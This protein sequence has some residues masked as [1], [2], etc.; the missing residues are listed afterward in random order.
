[1]KDTILSPTYGSRAGENVPQFLIFL[2]ASKSQDNV[3]DPAGALKTQGVVPFGVGVKDADPK[4][5]AA[6]SHN[7]SFAFNVKEF[8][9]LSA[10]HQRLNN[11]VSLPNE[12]LEEIL[13]QGKAKYVCSFSAC[14]VSDLNTTD[15]RRDIVFLLDGSDE[16]RN[17]LPAIREFIRRITD[18]LDIDGEMIR[19]AVVQYSDNAVPHFLF[20][21]HKTKKDVIYAVRSLRPKGGGSLNTGAALQYVRDHVFVPTSGNRH[22]M[23]VPQVLLVLTGRK[24]SD[25]VAGPAADLRRLGILTFAIGMKN[26]EEKELRKIAYSARFLFNLPSFGELLSIQSDILTFFQS[27][28]EKEPPT[29][30]VELD[31]AQRDIV[32][33]LDGSEDTRD[34]FPAM[35]QFVENV[36]EKLTVNPNSDQVSVVQYSSDP[37]VYFHLNTYS[38]KQDVL[39]A[40]RSLRLKGGRPQNLGM[41]LDYVRKNVFVT[42]SGSRRLDGVPQI[43]IVLTGGRSQDDI[44]HPASSLKQENILSFTIGTKK[45]DIIQLQT[46]AHMPSYTVSIS[47]FED[48]QNIQQT[49]VSF[50]NDIVFLIDASDQSRNFELMQNFIERVVKNLDFGSNKNQ[51]AVVQYSREAAADFFLNTHLK[52]DDIIHNVRTLTKKGGGPLNTGAALQYVV[53]NTFDEATGS[54]HLEGVPQILILLNGGRSRDDIRG[55]AAEL[56]RTGVIPISIGTVGSDTLELQTISHKPNYFFMINDSEDL[57][58]VEESVLSLVKRIRDAT[59]NFY[60]NSYSTKADALNSIK[61]LQHKSGHQ[62]S[63]VQFSSTPAVDFYLN[64][65]TSRESLSNAIRNLKPKGGRP[66]YTGTALKF[67]K[68]NVFTQNAGSRHLDGAYQILIV[69]VGGRSRESV[70]GPASALQTMGVMTFAIGL[71]DNAEIQGIASQTDNQPDLSKRDIVFLVDGSDNTRNGFQAIRDFLY[72]VAGKLNVESAKDRISVIQF[73]NVAVAN[74]YLNS[75]TKKEDVLNSIKGL[76]HK[77]GRPLNTGKALQF[78][79]NNIFTASSGSRYKE[80]VPQI[81]VLVSS[82]RSKDTIDE[83]LSALKDIGVQIFPVGTRLSDKRELQ[84][85][86]FDSSFTLAVSE[87]NDLPLIQDFEFSKCI[88]NNIIFSPVPVKTSKKDVVFL[89]DGTDGTR[90]GFPAMKDFVQRL[91]EKLNITANKDRVSVVQYSREPE[92]H[93]YLNTYERKQDIV[94]TVR[95]LRHKGGRPLNTGAALQYVRDNVFTPSSGS[96]RLDG[97]PQMLILLSGGRSFDNVYTPASSL[98]ELG[99]QIFAIGTRSA[100]ST[101][102]QRISKDP[103]SAVS[104]SEF[105]DLPNVQQQLLAAVEKDVVF[106][107]DGSDGT[108]NGFPSMKDFVQRVV[109][110]LNVIDDKDR[111]AVVQYSREPEVHFYLNT[112]ERKQDVLDTVKGLTHKGGRPLNTG[113]ALQYVRDNVFTPSSGSRRLDGVPQMLILLSGGRSFDNVYTPATSLRDLGVQIFTIGSRNADSTELQRISKDPSS[114]IAVS[115]FTDLPNVQQQLLVLAGFT[116]RPE[117]PTVLGMLLRMP[118]SIREPEVHFYLNTYERKQDIVDTVRGLR[119]KGGRPLNTGAALQYVRDN[120]FTPSSG[121]RRLDGVPQMLILLSGGRSFDNVYTPASS[122]KELGV[123]IFAIGT[124]SADISEFTDLPNVQQQL[125]A[126]VESVAVPSKPETPTVLGMSVCFISAASI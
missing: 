25:D 55:P 78:V 99:V 62:V 105:T 63:V 109:E 42:S 111:V 49:L 91:V 121:S 56:K 100:D 32:F 10:V 54:R 2:T 125:L 73:S 43:L 67:V 60:L 15:V 34:G 3:R 126:A 84:N 123:Q 29:V 69:V 37:Q 107:L 94:D 24:S 40:I 6:I 97:V 80:K 39:N 101:E 68:D 61:L 76:N 103:S 31:A 9:Q 26:A 108:R 113:A 44:R 82:G 96:R 59:A 65:H 95:G 19:V 41:A 14:A 112:Y 118:C 12:Q 89:L 46:V 114:A 115:E 119:H 90:N 1:M 64:T 70:H 79:K 50:L 110:K 57:P 5:I 66:Y 98:K 120:V 11:F 52:K 45:A 53:N 74:F 117:T 85:I 8:S 36:V 51:V 23:G 7:P 93:F 77:G 16:S 58:A 33:L 92:V 71:T 18:E 116:T 72:S 38:A 30:V 87:L 75:F 48:L 47:E 104:V 122:L 35:C 20:T 22:H 88:L 86:S 27:K 28:M 4:Q 106:L 17:G 124:R 83:P 102:L 81:L 13:V 21:T